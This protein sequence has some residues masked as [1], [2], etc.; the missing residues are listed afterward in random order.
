MHSVSFGCFVFSFLFLGGFPF[1][2][3]MQVD[4]RG[5]TRRRAQTLLCM[6]TRCIDLK[7]Q[8]LE[9]YIH[10]HFS[11]VR[12]CSLLAQR[13]L[14]FFLALHIQRAFISSHFQMVYFKGRESWCWL[15][16]TAPLPLYNS[17]GCA[18]LC[19]GYRRL[20]WFWGLDDP[21]RLVLQ[22]VQSF[23]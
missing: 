2:D 22:Y 17:F 10:Q 19:L 14:S 7:L 20:T 12:I 5:C 1:L 13:Q 6:S 18:C 23:L 3:Y 8:K 9:S 16:T 11:T 21:K 4:C 15:H